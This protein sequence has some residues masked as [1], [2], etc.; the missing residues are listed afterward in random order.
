M[1]TSAWVIA[2]LPEIPNACQSRAKKGAKRAHHSVVIDERQQQVDKLV[3]GPSGEVVVYIEV[4]VGMGGG[5]PLAKR[6]LVPA[7]DVP[8]RKRTGARE[9]SALQSDSST[10]DDSRHQHVHSSSSIWCKD[11]KTCQ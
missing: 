8:W 9:K 3:A 2:A 5:E 11:N 10:A 4:H 7:S 6:G 1:W